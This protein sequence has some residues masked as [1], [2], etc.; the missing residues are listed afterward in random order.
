VRLTTSRQELVHRGALLLED[1]LR[2]AS[3]PEDGRVLFV[4]SLSLGT[5]SAR[6]SRTDVTRRVEAG[7]GD[8]LA[9]AVHGLHPS[10]PASDAVYFRD[11]VESYASLAAY[12]AT[13][14]PTDAWF[15]Q[16]VDPRWRPSLSRD[17]SLR[18]LLRS[19]LDTPAGVVA[20]AEVVRQVERRGAL[21]TLLSAL[22]WQD[23]PTLLAACG[24]SAA[25]ADT[26][27]I[28]GSPRSTHAAARSLSSSAER[29]LAQWVRRW[30][31]S[32]ARSSWLAG[33]LLVSERSIRAVDSGLPAVLRALV[34][35]VAHE[36]P[37]ESV[38]RNGVA[39]A[40][41]GVD[42]SAMESLAF[43][44]APAET[45]DEAISME[46]AR[47]RRPPS[48]D[49]T[50][51]REK[52]TTTSGK[53]VS[54]VAPRHAP[55]RESS[56]R[57]NAPVHDADELHA[58]FP[59]THRPRDDKARPAHEPGGELESP[60]GDGAAG[61]VK[62][63][64]SPPSRG[65]S[66]DAAIAT[67]VPVEATHDDHP[68]LRA[69]VDRAQRTL[70]AM[71][72]EHPTAY[73]GYFYLIPLLTRLQMSAFLDAHPA[74]VD[75][76]LPVR[77]LARLDRRLGL[78]ERDAALSVLPRHPAGE[79]LG[80]DGVMSIPESW[81]PF[82]AAVGRG[83]GRPPRSG[84]DLVLASWLVVMRR[85]CRAQARMG[86]RTLISRP[87]HIAST[88]THIDVYFA[89]SQ[90]DMQVR[91]TGLDV[92]PGWVPWLGRVV[93]FHYRPTGARGGE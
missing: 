3:L 87:A 71:D 72:D 58:A 73:G 66:S 31:A 65:D 84:A 67:P 26:S 63:P 89:L 13:Q 76:D 24:W 16:L 64:Q 45:K 90:V 55:T 79:P 32:D 78:D 43:R 81:A 38:E 22:R 2:T 10:A 1:A 40:N 70:H 8:L 80:W 29:T 85:W 77:L 28:G 37:H 6:T 46:D 54:P 15:W 9:R 33:V 12:V 69:D 25:V 59:A 17:E 50:S 82:V 18:A 75:W 39:G 21:D 5:V 62:T 19:A 4:R 36:M 83:P 56:K 23:G 92:N 51:P 93:Q 35:G 44:V 30:G 41:A 88:R 11:A 86:L 14:R 60:V 74:L 20:A 34:V 91:L 42:A 7:V 68:P 57:A 53:P 61:E 27:D 52:A 48:V 47:S 49:R